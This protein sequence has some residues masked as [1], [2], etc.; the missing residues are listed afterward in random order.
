MCE[1]KLAMLKRYY[2]KSVTST[3]MKVSHKS[4]GKIRALMFYLQSDVLLG[5]VSVNFLRE[6]HFYSHLC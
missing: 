4:N 1:K 3:I 5:I 2:C 6:K